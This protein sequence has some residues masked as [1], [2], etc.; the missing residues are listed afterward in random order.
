MLLTER[1]AHLLRVVPGDTVRLKAQTVDDVPNL[2]DAEVVGVVR[3]PFSAIDQSTFFVPLDLARELLDMPEGATEVLI[4]LRD[5]DASSEMSAA[6]PDLLGPE[7]AAATE[8]FD[9]RHYEPALVADIAVDTRF[10]AIFFAV[11][12]L[13]SAFIMSNSMSMTVF[14]RTR[15]LA[16][17]RA[18]GLS[19]NGLLALVSAESALVG[20]LGAVAGGLAGGL[21]CWY[22]GIYGIPTDVGELSS[23][24]VSPRFY[25]ISRPIEYLGSA[26]LGVMAGWLGGLRGALRARRL[27]IVEALRD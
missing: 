1:L 15:E 2:V 20:A 14:E 27:R 18:I 24:P 22:F 7:L 8:A 17:L 3:P 25:P 12:L 13:I 26:G 10:L 5:P 16:T 11:L 4:A 9:W 6:I 23:T 19:G 21:L